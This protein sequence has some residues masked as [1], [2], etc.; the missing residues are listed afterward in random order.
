MNK[1]KL[2]FLLPVY[3]PFIILVR[4]L[5]PWLILRFG[6]F[7]GD[8]IGHF[9]GNIEIYLCERDAGLNVPH[10]R[11]LDILYFN[12]SVCNNQLR[13]MWERIIHISPIDLSVFDRLNRRFSGG[14]IHSILMPNLDRDIYGFL[15][16]TQP[17]LFFTHD[18]EQRGKAG[19]SAL[20]IP[21]NALFICF[22]ARDSAYMKTISPDVDF[23]YHNYR[24]SNIN[25]YLLAAEELTQRGKFAIRMGAVVAEE[26]KCKNPKIIDYAS[27]GARTDFMDV[28]LGSKCR[29]FISSGTGIDAIP[30]VFRRPSAFVNFVP[31]EYGRFW[32]P[33][34][35]FIPKKHWLCNERRFMTFHEILDSGAGRFLD[36]KLFK[37]RGIELIENTSEEIR[38][39]VVEMDMRLDK[40]WQSNQ[41][42]EELQRR[43]W[44]LFSQS[45]INGVFNAR[46]GAA[47]LRQHKNLL[48]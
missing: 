35:L 47:F 26:I 42:D 23:N 43:F 17:H 15:A 12:T 21:E 30:M 39:L 24:D 36:G 2:I 31:L 20:N 33:E 34:H 38:D 27:N 4:L 1:L 40:T 9:A 19:L 3:L 37:Q 18:E 7:I 22:H 29:F 32:Q 48:E 10:K 44:L 13:K 41:E 11:F 25:N 5:R 8:R 6:P 14:K 46:I 28:Y 45:D 16:K